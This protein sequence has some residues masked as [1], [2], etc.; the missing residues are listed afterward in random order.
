[1]RR[2]VIVAALVSVAALAGQATAGRSGSDAHAVVKWFHTPGF[3]IQCE[4]AS[5]D[6]RGTY[7]YC[8]SGKPPRS[9]QMRLDGSVKICQGGLCIG[10][11]PENAATLPTGQSV[12]VGPFR[13]RSG[14]TSMRC[15]AGAHGFVIGPSGVTVH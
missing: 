6:S 15:T 1:M 12:A 10:D 13:C 5:K 7:A 9:A 14:G 4:V 2:G 11:G 3:N 8:Q